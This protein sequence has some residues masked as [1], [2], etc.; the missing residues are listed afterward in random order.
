MIATRPSAKP[1]RSPS[2]DAHYTGGNDLIALAGPAAENFYWTTSYIMTSEEGPGKDF[3]LD[4]AK[5][6]GRD[7]KTA[8]SHNYANGVMVAQV[9]YRGHGG[10][11]KRAG[12]ITKEKSLR[13][14]GH[15]RR[16]RLS[17]SL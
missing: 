4:L 7:D 14:A 9:A 13:N 8:N 11:R 15:E 12:A 3:Q 1:A 2:W 10:P 5:K 6:Y 16:Q 17:Q